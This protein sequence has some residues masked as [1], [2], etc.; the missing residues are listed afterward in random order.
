MTKKNLF[1]FILIVI[2]ILNLF[3]WSK[4]YFLLQPE[5]V[6]VLFFDV[7]QGDSIF[8]ETPEGHQMLIDGGPGIAVLEKLGK[9]MPFWDRTIDLVILT[10]PE[11][12][13]L[14]GILEVLKNYKVE[15]IL[16]TGVKRDTA[17]FQEWLGLIKEEG[18]NI[19]IAQAGQRISW[20]TF[21]KEKEYL[22][23]LFPLDNLEGRELK[24]A[25]N[26]SVVIKLVFWENEFLF[27][28][29]IEAVIERKLLREGVDVNS[30]VLKVAHHGSKTSSL[31]EFIE[32]VSP[33]VAVIQVGSENFYGH[34]ATETLE[35]LEN[36]GINIFRTDLQGDIKLTAN[37]ERIYGVSDF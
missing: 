14:S 15:N 6:K 28:S 21:E 20:G 34:P 36:Y 5:T 25:N 1:S 29:D 17:E 4:V 22:D 2:F 23:V 24:S 13:H 12:D 27:T 18:A 37:K 16:W 30:D 7:G 10:H 26:S 9:V 3:A 11:Y 31:A 8:I 19:Y 35:V 32:K 33:E